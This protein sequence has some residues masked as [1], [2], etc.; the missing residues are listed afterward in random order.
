MDNPILITLRR[1]K[2]LSTTTAIF[3]F[4]ALSWFVIDYFIL[5][6]LIEKNEIGWS[7]ELVLL[8]FSGAVFL[9][10]FLLVLLL[11]FYGFR[12]IAKFKTLQK[13]S[14]KNSSNSLI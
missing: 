12:L 10:F 13:D 14:S 3:S 7:I 4:I 5:K 8:V 1:F 11:I 6:D 2:T 9:I